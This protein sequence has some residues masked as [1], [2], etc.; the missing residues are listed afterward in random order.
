MKRYT[1]RQAKAFTLIEVLVAMAVISISLLAAIK[2]AS[3]VTTSAIYMQDK[4]LA[5]WVAMNKVAEMRLQQTWPS[6]GRSNGDVE[7]A[8]RSWHWKMEVK[9]TEDKDVRRLEVG[10]MPE[11]EKDAETPTVLL[12]AFLGKPV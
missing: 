8:D 1:F 2:V 3:E 10:V 4:T 9:A 11:S 7:M 6:I 5:H 12:I